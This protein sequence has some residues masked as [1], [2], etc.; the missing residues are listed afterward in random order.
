VQRRRREPDAYRDCDDSSSND[1]AILFRH[2]DGRIVSNPDAYT[3]AVGHSS[4]F[5]DGD[6]RTISLRDTDAIT[7]RDDDTIFQL[8]A[9]DDRLATSGR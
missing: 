5:H 4:P 3:V 1:D 9:N 2:D 7:V 8:H 6:R